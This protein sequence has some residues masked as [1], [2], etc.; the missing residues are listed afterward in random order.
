MRR[1]FACAIVSLTLCVLA[2]AQDSFQIRYFANLNVGDSYV[3]ITNG[4]SNNPSYY[5]GSTSPQNICANVYV[6]NPD[7]TMAACCSCVI[8]PDGLVSLSVRSDLISNT[9]TPAV[10]TS[11]VVKLLA[12]LPPTSSP[13]SCNAGNPGAA[14]AGLRAWGTTLHAGPTAGVYQTT[15]TEFQITPLST[16]ER[17]KLAGTCASIIANDASFGICR[18][19]RLGGL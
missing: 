7:A 19:C 1:T 14:A 16:S 10:P 17:T 4:G 12:T 13:T 8:V 9:A 18:S 11:V 6:F 2:Q 5:S 3:D 15:E